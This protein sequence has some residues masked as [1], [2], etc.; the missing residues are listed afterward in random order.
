[1]ARKSREQA[2]R[3]H[4]S[5]EQALDLPEIL[6][7]GVPHIELQGDAELALDGCKGI[8]EY[9]EESIRLHAGVLLLSVGGSN[10]CI[11]MYSEAQTVI[12]GDIRQIALERVTA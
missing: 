1:M 8:L 11:R 5:V 2:K 4:P 12:T 10:L 6:H 7:K 3:A 9:T